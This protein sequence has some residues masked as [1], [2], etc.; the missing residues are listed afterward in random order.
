MTEGRLFGKNGKLSPLA[1]E[2]HKKQENLEEKRVPFN[3]SPRPTKTKAPKPIKQLIIDKKKD[4]YS[5]TQPVEI[6]DI[7]DIQRNSNKVR[8][9]L[10]DVDDISFLSPAETMF[11]EDSF[12]AAFEESQ[13]HGEEEIHVRS[14]IVLSDSTTK[15]NRLHQPDRTLWRTP[16][17][18]FD[19]AA[20]FEWSCRFCG[21]TSTRASGGDV[22][23]DHTDDDFYFTGLR[24]RSPTASP[25]SHPTTFFQGLDDDE[26][27][28]DFYFGGTTNA[29]TA[30]L[31][32][33][34]TDDIFYLTGTKTYKIDS[35]SFTDTLGEDDDIFSFF[36]GKRLLEESDERRLEDTLCQKLRAGPHQAFHQ[37]GEC[38]VVFMT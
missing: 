2:Q 17:K 11:F 3:P 15:K 19:I 13:N 16:G 35:W 21:T 5:T 36:F 6:V 26:T 33:V 34:Y 29:F 30:P 22:D 9:T 24:E 10:T 1:K 4:Q 18:Y 31:D 8:V 12:M 7:V 37:I 20:L 14:M 23:D 25:T 38:F 28:D 32:D 27:D